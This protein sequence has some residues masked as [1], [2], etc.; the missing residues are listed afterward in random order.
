MREVYASSFKVGRLGV[1][2]DGAVL[3][4]AAQAVLDWMT[5]KYEGAVVEDRMKG[6]FTIGL[7]SAQ[8]R[9]DALADAAASLWH[10]EWDRHDDDGMVWRTRCQLAHEAC[11]VRFTIRIAIDSS[12]DRLAP[13]RYEVGRPAVIPVLSQ[14][15][16]IHQDGRRLG[17]QPSVASPGGIPDLVQLLLNPARRLPVVVLTPVGESGNGPVDPG[18]L[19]FR[20]IGLAHVVQ[21]TERNATLQLRD[22]L[23]QLLCVFGGAL[24]LYWPGFSVTSNPFDHPLWLLPR[25]EAAER[26]DAGVA[27]RLERQLAAVGVMRVRPDPL[28]AALRAQ[29]DRGVAD[30]IARLEGDIARLKERPEDPNEDWFAQLE[31]AWDTIKQQQAQVVDLQRTVGDLETELEQVRAAFVISARKDSLDDDAEIA[32]PEEATSS[33]EVFAYAQQ[34]LTGLVV[35]AS[36]AVDLRDLDAA[37]EARGWAKQ[38]WR[39][40]RA[41]HEYALQASAHNGFWDFCER[42]GRWPANADNLALSESKTVIQSPELREKR[43]FAIDPRVDSSGR[44]I[45]YSHLKVVGGGGSNIPRIYF[46]DDTKGSTG[47]VHIGFFGPHRHVPNKSTN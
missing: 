37:P 22:H 30:Q 3:G 31:T 41:L 32:I 19:A 36:A 2:A 28:E 13:P 27:K 46:H 10:L 25:I 15:V 40:L 9:H 20:L 8:W 1:A 33:T 26:S 11:E 12:D 35:P 24:R 14:R 47:K 23:G 18:N 44:Q 42:S 6:R 5:G 38:A 45:M 39:G 16:G 34:F 29:R 7:D 4:E 21:V 17:P 43:R